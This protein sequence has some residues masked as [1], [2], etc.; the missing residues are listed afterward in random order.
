MQNLHN[1]GYNFLYSLVLPF[2][3]L[4]GTSAIF[5][6]NVL[7]PSLTVFD[8]HVFD[9]NYCLKML[10]VSFCSQERF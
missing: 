4:T 2:H 8:K 9:K 6:V 7:E 10:P 3:L 1:L 5:S